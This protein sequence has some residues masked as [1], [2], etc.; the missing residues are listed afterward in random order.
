MEIRKTLATN[1]KS[2][3]NHAGIKS[4]AQL[5][6]LTGISQTQ[7]SNILGHKK[8]ASTDLL[9]RLAAGLGCEPWLLLT[10]VAFLEEYGQTDYASL[11]YC[12]MRLRPSAQDAVWEMTHQL[13]EATNFTTGQLYK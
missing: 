8:A 12:Y 2:L 13:Y 9:E 10:P 4:Q 11:V 6:Q 3:M 1:I 5:A 7:I